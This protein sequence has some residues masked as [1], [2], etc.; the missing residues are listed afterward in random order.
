MKKLPLNFFFFLIVATNIYG[1][2]VPSSQIYSGQDS[3]PSCTSA[4]GNESLEE[5]RFLICMLRT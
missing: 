4:F 1:D 2:C 3:G 5:L